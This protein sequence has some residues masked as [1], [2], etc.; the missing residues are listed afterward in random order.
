M[1]MIYDDES[2]KY[3]VLSDIQAQ[4][5]FLGDMDFKVAGTRK[6]IT[7]LQMDTKI[8]GLTLAIIKEVFEQAK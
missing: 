8:D 2:K 7:A 3:V 5:D 1:G 6:G 4:E